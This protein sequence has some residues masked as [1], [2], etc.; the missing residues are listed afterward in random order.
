[1]SNPDKKIDKTTHAGL[2]RRHL[3]SVLTVSLGGLAVAIAGIPVVGFVF[4]K[5]FRKPNQVW[6][7]VGAVDSFKVGTT[8]PV[9]FENVPE[10]PWDG[11]AAHTAA[12]LR[13]VSK[14]EFIAFSVNCTH[15]GCPV[16][17]KPQADLFMCPCHGGVYYS[18]GSVAGGPP[19]RPLPRYNVRVSEGHVEIQTAP[20][21]INAT[22]QAKSPCCSGGIA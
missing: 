13:R 8:T 1:M 19:P 2:S 22:A 17:W 14:K 4:G 5:M 21:P 7:R 16:Q 11:V 10:L 6:K 9:M 20:I 12:W 3:L 18:D 15:L